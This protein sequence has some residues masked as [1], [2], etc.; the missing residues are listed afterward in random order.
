MRVRILWNELYAGTAYRARAVCSMRVRLRVQEGL[1]E[2]PLAARRGV[3]GGVLISFHTRLLTGGRVLCRVACT[4]QVYFAVAP[5]SSL[6][7][8]SEVAPP[9]PVPYWCLTSDLS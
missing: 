5:P 2:Q 3:E 4:Y 1:A 9:S 8:S 6:L 7:R